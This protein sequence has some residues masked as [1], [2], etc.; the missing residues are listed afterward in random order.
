MEYVGIANKDYV[1]NTLDKLQ[2]IPNLTT[3]PSAKYPNFLPSKKIILL[4]LGT[5]LV[6]KN[7][8]IRL[9]TETKIDLSINAANNQTIDALYADGY[10]LFN[11]KT[12]KF[13]FWPRG[14]KPED[15]DYLYHSYVR[16]QT[17]NVATSEW[18]T[19]T[20][21]LF[22]GVLFSPQK[23]EYIKQLSKS[24]EVPNY[25]VN[26]LDDKISEIDTIILNQSVH[27]DNFIF[28]TDTHDADNA[29]N[30][31]YLINYLRKRT[32]ITTINYGGDIVSAFG[33]NEQMQSQIK[34]HKSAFREFLLSKDWFPVPGNH[35][36]TI[37]FESGEDAGTTMTKTQRNRIYS[38]DVDTYIQFP[39]RDALY[40]YRDN[41]SQK[42]RY[43]YIDCFDTDYDLTTGWG[44]KYGVSQTQVDWVLSTLKQENYLLHFGTLS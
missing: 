4:P 12:Q 33:S 19:E 10:V 40:Y 17:N 31:S 37:K 27:A 20:S 25:W 23:I 42:I 22:E 7:L 11:K 35:D 34:T 28:I 13:E 14:F 21:H 38:S 15:R 30:S 24:D 5:L 2:I 6:S 29:L 18:V 9:A 32:S 41:L 8:Q 3:N 39:S 16:W 1:Y 44:V 26:Y 43:I 36:F